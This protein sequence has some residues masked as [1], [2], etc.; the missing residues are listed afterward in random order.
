MKEGKEGLHAA[1]LA[2]PGAGGEGI[3]GAKNVCAYDGVPETNDNF[4]NAFL[5]FTRFHSHMPH[6]FFTN[7]HGKRIRVHLTYTVS[8]N[9][10]VNVPIM[11]TALL[12]L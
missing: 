2:A 1:P 3:E 12:Q 5:L 8:P 10:S 11:R 9:R 4:L 7:L 6:T